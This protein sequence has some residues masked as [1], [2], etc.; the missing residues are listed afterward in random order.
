[1]FKI[2]Y[3]LI[4]LILGLFVTS[5]LIDELILP[6][7]W[8]N[9]QLVSKVEY[10]QKNEIYPNTYFIGSSNIFRQIQPTIFDNST[11]KSTHSFNLGSDGCFP[12]HNIY[13]LDNLL[14]SRGEKIKYIFLE[15][16]SYDDMDDFRYR[17]TKSIYSGNLKQYLN[18][19]K[20]IHSLQLDKQKKIYYLKRYTVSYLD[21]FFKIG[22]RKDLLTFLY[23]GNLF[24]DDM[25]G[26]NKDGYLAL[27]GEHTKNRVQRNYIPR[28]MSELKYYLTN[29][30][31]RKSK[32]E[33]YNKSHLKLLNNYIQKL[34]KRDI[35]L[36]C[37]LLPK[38]FK[39]E[40]HKS[41]V[42]LFEQL[43]SNHKIDLA[44]PNKFPLFFIDK[45]R[46]DYGHLN[47]AGSKLFTQALAEEFNKISY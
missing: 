41:I 22:M 32:N 13:L 5:T 14:N 3:K 26:E 8:G 12:E 35:Q 2:I 17:T 34:K 1:M 18:R 7:Y 37:L 44:N 47:N 11:R 15:L 10:L 42:G 29:A 24:G 23:H 28:G 21:N 45:Y 30:Y 25:V 39:L 31:G 40:N 27:A 43:P 6:W 38:P 9:P 20:Y 4:L 46:W 36:I 16:N 19:L 33:D